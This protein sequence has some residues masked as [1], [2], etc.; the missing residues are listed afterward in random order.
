L[1]NPVKSWSDEL[2]TLVERKPLV[3]LRLDE[4]E[5]EALRESRRGVGE[6]TTALPHADFAHVRAPTLCLLLAKVEGEYHAYL[7][8]IGSRSA[9][10]TLQSRVKIRRAVRIEPAAPDALV[11]LLVTAAHRKTLAERL[12][13]GQDLAALSPKLSVQLIDR[14]SLIEQNA[15]LCGLWLQ[16]CQHP[17]SFETTP[18]SRTMQSARP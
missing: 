10:T 4:A 9:I 5:W 15:G 2:K 3:V 14:L 18:P 6:F 7:G 12:A 17:A 8:V 16:P 1:A 13:R 11:G